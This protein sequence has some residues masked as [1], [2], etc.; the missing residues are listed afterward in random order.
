MRVVKNRAKSAHFRQ[1]PVSFCSKSIK[2]R[3]KALILGFFYVT[4]LTPYTK[5]T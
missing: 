1:F 3:A 2:K 5:T 4:T